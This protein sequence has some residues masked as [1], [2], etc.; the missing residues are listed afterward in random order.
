M[1]DR[2]RVLPV[3]IEA[4]MRRSYIDYAMSVIVS[5]AL[6]DVRDGLKPVHRRILYAMHELGNTPNQPYKKSA[7]IVG[8]VLGRY[9]PHGEVAV[10][11]AMVRMAQDF[12]S[13]YVLVDGHGN[14]GSLDGDPP[15]AMRYTE[16]RLSP[17]ATEMLADIDKDTVAFVP[18]FDEDTTEPTVLPARVPNLL[19]NGS[20]GIAVGMATNIPPHNLSEVVDAAIYLIDHPTA[21]VDDLMKLVPGPDF[22]TGGL[23]MGREGIR[24]AY[25]TGRGIIVMRGVATAEET[26]QG[27]LR[28]LISEIPFQ[29]NKARMLEKIAE[30]VHERK[31]EGVSDL[32]DESDRHGVRVVLELKRDAKPRVILNQ[33]Y[34]YTP[35][36]QTFGIIMLALVGGRPVVLSLPELLEQFI[37]H[38]KD[39]VVRRTR[40]ELNRAEARAHILEGLRIALEHLDEV[41][42]LIRASAN[43]EE[44]RTG[45]MTRFGLSEK[46]AQA[47]LDMRLQRLTAL[48]RDKIEAEYREVM[49]EIERLRAILADEQL[50]LNLIKDEL[51]EVKTK[52]GDTR[53]TRITGPVRD[54]EDDDLIPEE[55]MVVTLT[56]RGYIKRQ[57]LTLYRSQRRGGRG[58]TGSPTR[59]D[60]F[61]AHLFTASTHDYLCFFTNQGRA[62]RLKVHE[63]PE[64]S[65]QAKGTAVVNL[66]NLEPGERI[67]AVQALKPG[68]SDVH[69]IFATKKG[70]VK[71]TPVEAYQS[72]RAMGLI[73]ISLDE[74]D[75]LIG[76]EPTTGA[77]DILLATQNGL[78]IRFQADEVRPM[79]RQARGVTGI[80]LRG[81]DRVVSLAC[82]ESL[83]ELLLLSANGFGKRSP[84]NQFRRTGRGGH[85]IIGMRCTAK[86]GPLVSIV[87]VK[88]D[89]EIMIISAEGTMIRLAVSDISVQG[90]ASQGVTIMRLAESGEVAAVAVIRGDAD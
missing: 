32:R 69:W 28:I 42:Q 66:L 3:D 60:D 85:G 15:A 45:L 80:R 78:V 22:P 76:V 64:A 37:A 31:I 63:I 56:H 18:N 50:V 86:T 8:E 87:P 10:Y 9:H 74:G 72:W 26:A 75:E 82:V 44:A 35:L 79:G 90:R 47:I 89:E 27:R 30:L 13:R 49:A 19:I 33:L 68:E 34:K 40:F 20:A 53:R 84:L 61:V 21:T 52:Y 46:Q 7:R 25:T 88:G 81:D 59:E 17:L 43:A 67:A 12:A 62:Y 58:V 73:A 2:G 70:T 24:Q 38:R 54:L 48:E 51:T 57:P 83:P 29:V 11:D 14:F 23:I 36:Q 6:P 16:V 1:A 39:V 41:I 65:R 5:R 55:E 71:R 4:E 77:G